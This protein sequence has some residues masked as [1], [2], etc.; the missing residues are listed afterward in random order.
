MSSAYGSCSSPDE[1]GD[2]GARFR[3]SATGRRQD[4]DHRDMAGASDAN[5]SRIAANRNRQRAL[6]GAPLGERVHRL[7]RTLD[8]SQARLART[9]GISPA[10]LSQLVSAR[11][12][13]LGHPG[14]LARLLLLDRRCGDLPAPRRPADVDALLAEV[15]RARWEWAAGPDGLGR[16]PD[17][18]PGVGTAH[19]DRPHGRSGPPVRG[20]GAGTAADALRGITGPARLAAAAAALGTAFPELAEVLRQAAGRPRPVT[21]VPRPRD[22]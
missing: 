10:M 18:M 4:C 16:A 3:R 19:R 9:L 1:G 12:V 22:G 15:A 13:K 8:I 11:R 2:H 14:A 21:R 7:T 17:R 5:A 6:Y 20:T